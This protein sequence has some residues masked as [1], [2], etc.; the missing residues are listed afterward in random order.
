MW[1]LF[2]AAVLAGATFLYVPGMLVLLGF[3]VKAPLAFA[4]APLLGIPFIVGLTIAYSFLG[5]DSNWA[6][7]FLPQLAVGLLVFAVGNRQGLCCGDGLIGGDCDS[8]FS[9]SKALLLYMAAGIAVSTVMFVTFLQDPM[10]YVQEYDNVAHMGSIRSFVDSGNWS[11]FATSL[12]VGI[13]EGINPLYDSGFYPSAW[14]DIAAFVVS[15][16]GVPV[17]LSENA[18]NFVFAGIVYPVSMFAFMRA[19]FLDRSKVAYWGAFCVLA[20]SAFPWKTLAWGPLFPN[21]AAFCLLPLISSVFF[22]LLSEGASANNRVF[23]LA[24]FLLGLVALVFS[25]PNAVFS[26]GVWMAPYLVYRIGLLAD[27]L[28]FDGAIRWRLRILFAAIAVFAV[29]VVWAVLYHLPFLQAVVQNPWYAMQSKPEAFLSAFTLGFMSSGT[30]LVLVL[31]VVLG[32]LWTLRN[33]RWLWLSVSFTIACGMFVVDVS[34]DGPLQH[35]LTGFWYADYYRVAAMAAIFGVPLASIG[36]SVF[37]SWLERVFL[38]AVGS[39]RSKKTRRAAIAFALAALVAG[40]AVSLPGGGLEGE[41]DLMH[42]LKGNAFVSAWEH[43]SWENNVDYIY[44]TEE[45]E[46]VKMVKEVL[47]QGA[48][49]INNPNDGSCFCYVADDLRIYYRYLNTYGV[50]GESYDSRLIR[51]RLDAIAYDDQVKEAVQNVGAQYVLLLDQGRENDPTDLDSYFFFTYERRGLWSGIDLIRD[52]TPGF[53][54]VLAHNDMRLYRI[55]AL[56]E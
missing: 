54:V 15:L 52:A 13:D 12:Y 9:D 47:P 34:S 7:V 1:G 3:R 41:S 2:F 18:T 20:F 19:V 17:T 24:L 14:Y 38:R 36:I 23:S 29:C 11:P 16:L 21:T 48:L 26:L 8:S 27:A 25:Q 53:E 35:L 42:K 10:H 30:Q 49:V 51:S 50:S 46:F 5:V 4:F 39:E 55:T 22:F 6:S 43:L 45:K 33:R 32:G 37:A 40:N 44:T 56:D 31:F 28:R